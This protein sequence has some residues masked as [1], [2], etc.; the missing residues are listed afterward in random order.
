MEG[1]L[2][3]SHSLDLLNSISYYSTCPR[4][5]NAPIPLEFNTTFL[6]PPLIRPHRGTSTLHIG[7]PTPSFACYIH[8]KSFIFVMAIVEEVISLRNIISTASPVPGLPIAANVAQRIARLIEVRIFLLVCN[9]GDLTR[10]E[11]ELRYK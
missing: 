11:L 8:V 1:H 2:T 9:F 4:D 3:E 5:I 10:L 7:F 6:A